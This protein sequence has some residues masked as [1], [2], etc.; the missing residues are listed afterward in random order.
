[1]FY[2]KGLTMTQKIHQAIVHFGVMFSQG[3]IKALGWGTERFLPPAVLVW[4]SLKA[5]VLLYGISS[6]LGIDVSSSA[7]VELSNLT[8]LLPIE[9]AKKV[10]K[11]IQEKNPKYLMQISPE[12]YKIY[13]GLEA[14]ETGGWLKDIDTNQNVVKLKPLEIAEYMLGV[15]PLRLTQEQQVHYYATKTTEQMNQ[16]IANG[17]RDLITAMKNGD[18]DLTQ[19][20]L[21]NL[22]KQGLEIRPNDLREYIEQGEASRL[23]R[24]FIKYRKSKRETFFKILQKYYAK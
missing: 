20:I 21:T 23:I 6:F 9:D 3:G 12:A 10:L 24:D 18:W 8:S 14:I 19:N 13:K 17:K 1:L 16:L 2:P 5:P 15:N 22:K 4:L 11:A 7:T